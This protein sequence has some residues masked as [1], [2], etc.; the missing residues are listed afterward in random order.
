M[1]EMPLD[2]Q[3]YLNELMSLDEFETQNSFKVN[4]LKKKKC[5]ISYYSANA[6]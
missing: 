6:R 3:Q 1:S 4:S 2:Q 5:I